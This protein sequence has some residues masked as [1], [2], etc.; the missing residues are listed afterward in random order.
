MCQSSKESCYSLPAL[1]DRQLALG[2]YN[3]NA[4]DVEDR[5]KSTIIGA[6]NHRIFLPVHRRLLRMPWEVGRQRH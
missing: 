4:A 2:E 3:G 6:Q 5:E 1:V